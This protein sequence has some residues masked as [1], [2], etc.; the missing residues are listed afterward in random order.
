MSNSCI[1]KLLG[2][3][4]NEENR[5]L[6]IEEAL[7]LYE[8]EDKDILDLLSAANKVKLKYKGKKVNLCSIINAKS[9]RCPEDCKF[10]AQSSYYPTEISTYPLLPAEKITESAKKAYEM[11]AREFSIVTS[12]K[13][14]KT[15]KEIDTIKEAV[16]KIKEEDISPC[17]S[18]GILSYETLKELKEAGLSNYH[19]NLE[20]SKNFFPNIC[21]THNYEEDILAVKNAKKLGFYICSGGIFGIGE[22]KKDRIELALTLAELDVNSVPMNF[23]N[24]IKS[25]PLENERNLAPFEI[26]KTIAIFRLILKTKDIVIC[27]GRV[28]NLRDLHPFVL[29]AGANGLLTGN[30]LTTQ[31]RNPLDDRQMILDLQLELPE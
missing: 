10:C 1:H 11:G 19:H 23:L 6:D 28:I 12:G 8:I 13:G 27:G 15:K 7:S 4:L 25:T 21:S 22:S 20:T 26:L 24:P 18:L 3:I 17:A 30:Y 9:G 31:G 2:D 14:I 5:T 16:S 29:L